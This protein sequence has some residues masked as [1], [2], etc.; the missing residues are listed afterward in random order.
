MA[1][2][3]LRRKLQTYQSLYRVNRAFAVI[4]RQ[5]W[6][7]EQTGF[8]RIEKMKVFRGLVRELQSMISHDVADKMHAIEDHDMFEFGKVR[9][10][11]K[12][13]LNPD[14]PAFRDQ[15]K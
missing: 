7:L 8:L 10:A 13:Y 9:I 5:C 14:L 11:W 3:H 1:R 15:K 2:N 12:H 4:S 6:I